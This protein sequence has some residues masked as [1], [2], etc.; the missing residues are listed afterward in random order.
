MEHRRRRLLAGVLLTF[1]LTPATAL[2]TEVNVRI[3]G[4][5]PAAQLGPTTVDTRA[6]G[7]FGPDDCPNASA[8]GAVD[9]AVKQNWDRRA[10]TQTVLGETHAFTRN[11]FWALWINLELAQVG[12]CDYVPKAGDDLLLVASVS[13]PATFAPTPTPLSL[14]DVPPGA[15]AGEP[16]TVTV[17]QHASPDGVRTTTAP[18][19]GATV[20]AGDTSATTGPDGK[21]TL[22]LD[23]PGRVQLVATRAGNVSTDP[24][25]LA[26]APEEDIRSPTIALTNVRDGERFTRR[27]APRRLRGTARDEGPIRRVNLSVI[28]K[29]DGDC[30]RLNRRSRFVRSD[31]DRAGDFFLVAQRGRWSMPLPKLKP[32]RYTVRAVAVDAADNRSRSLLVRFRVVGS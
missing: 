3:A 10:L 31:C 14:R 1:A 28:R 18:V 6:D 24:I 4:E 7:T 13:D 8:G 29:R 22:Q 2:A 17:L 25:Q 12:L 27:T 11:D 19:A 26:V 32:G 21:A 16:F 20:T 9:L 30:R 23:R 5:T 15:T